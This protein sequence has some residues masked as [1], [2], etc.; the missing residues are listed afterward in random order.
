M[1]EFKDR[2]RFAMTY[3]QTTATEL[4]FRTGISQSRISQYRKGIYRP[5]SEAVKKIADALMVN[6]DWLECESEDMEIFPSF[7]TVEDLTPFEMRLL[8]QFQ[9]ADDNVKRG[10]CYILG[11]DEKGSKIDVIHTFSD[12]EINDI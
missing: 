8:N 9:K 12:S 2:L 11:I 6:P 4:A 7:K 10:I 5:K 3:R 1:G